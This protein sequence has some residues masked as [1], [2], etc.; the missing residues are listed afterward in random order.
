MTA[1]PRGAAT[2]PEA[3]TGAAPRRTAV[4][5][6]LL[7]ALGGAFLA[8]S[9]WRAR[10]L[11]ESARYREMA[12]QVETDRRA[13]GAAGETLLQLRA[14]VS[15][16]PGD[17]ESRLALA[18]FLWKTMGPA[19][20]LPVLDS[21]PGG[22]A[23]DPRVARMLADCAR[24]VGR[25]DLALAALNAAVAR[26]PAEPALRCDRA[27]L[28]VLLGWHREAEADLGRAG[29]GP[30]VLLARATLSRAR[31]DLAGARALLEEAARQRPGDAELLRQL[32]ALDVEAG[33]FTDALRRYREL[34]ADDRTSDDEL[35]Q[36]AA[37]YQVGTPELIR[38][39]LARVEAG[40]ARRPSGTALLLRSRCLEKLGRAEEA[41]RQLEALYREHPRKFGVAFELAERYR[42]LGRAAE[43]GPL[44]EGHRRD[45]AAR[46]RLRLAGEAVMRSPD[47]AAAHHELGML[48]LDAG[49]AGRAVVELERARALDPSRAGLDAALAGARKAA[50][51]SS[52]GEG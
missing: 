48:C 26:C 24:L 34:P 28:F 47:S 13:R 33:R 19:A 17:P 8:T 21:A 35:S 2:S 43:A 14:A 37:E 18:Q 9:S 6:G 31:S 23:S 3:R 10:L 29:A 16:R 44:L 12:A 5:L 50:V 46:T 1:R 27:T 52:D 38:A 41:L 42:R 22:G 30:E 45:Q 49:M 15:S 36:A 7:A 40:L 4:L 39:A 20:A 25:H 11:R 32:A 51:G